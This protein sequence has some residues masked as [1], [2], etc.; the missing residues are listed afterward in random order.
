M[1]IYGKSRNFSKYFNGFIY[2]SS[3]LFTSR[4]ILLAKIR[5]KEKIAFANRSEMKKIAQIRGLYDL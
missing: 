3:V 4:R 5:G 1:Q 2:K